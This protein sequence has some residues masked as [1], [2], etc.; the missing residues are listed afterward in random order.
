ME[1]NWSWAWANLWALPSHPR[2]WNHL[3]ESWK[4]FSNGSFAS[5]MSRREPA[6]SAIVFFVVVAPLRLG[7]KDPW[8][9][10]LWLWRWVSHVVGLPARG[11]CRRWS[12]WGY[13]GR[14]EPRAGGKGTTEAPA[15][16]C[17][18]HQRRSGFRQW[19]LLQFTAWYVQHLWI[20]Q[21]QSAGFLVVCR[22]V[23]CH[24]QR[25]NSYNI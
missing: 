20:L 4:A 17:Q 15:C 3:L 7:R 25:I 18:A 14:I 1:P 19:L 23:N 12:S 13:L 10:G 2:L 16:R 11:A 24:H 8:N 22:L 5:A 9:P 6:S 21:S